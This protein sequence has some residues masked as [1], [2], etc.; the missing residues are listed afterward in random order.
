MLQDC[1]LC[2]LVKKSSQMGDHCAVVQYGGKKAVVL[3]KHQSAPSPEAL[4]EAVKLV[5]GMVGSD[6]R[7][8][9][10][11]WGMEAIHVDWLNKPGAKYSDGNKPQA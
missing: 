6:I 7:E 9:A 11:H 5:E 10:G 4:K 1:P 8:V 3:L 2:Q